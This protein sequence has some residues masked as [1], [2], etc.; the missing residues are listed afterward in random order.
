V[1]LGNVRFAEASPTI[2]DFEGCGV[3][4]YVYDVACYWRKHVFGAVDPVN[5][6]RA[7]R[8][9]LVGY[10]SIRPLGDHELAA[11]PALA[12]LRAIWVMALPALPG[13]RWGTAWL[14]DASYFE[15]HLEVI[16]RFAERAHHNGP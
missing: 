8:E 15:A 12:T 16:A 3:G 6:A 11:V 10:G 9:F 5:A 2:F 7:W 13:A 14:E 1:H 4:P